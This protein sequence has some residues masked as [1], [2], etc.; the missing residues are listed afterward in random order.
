VGA[1]A[2]DPGGVAGDQPVPVRSLLDD[3]EDLLVDIRT[4]ADAELAYQKTRAR[5][6][7][8]SLKRTLAFGLAGAMLALFALGGLT[9]GL[10]IAL[11]PLVSAWGATAIVVG[12][13][14]VACFVALRMASKA[15][16]EM[17]GAV[18]EQDGET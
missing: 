16:R 10:I 13:L 14:L 5:F 18:R 2:P 11:T 12:A 8:D 4:W 7:G 9:I 3:A 15:W 1:G 17:M 6:V